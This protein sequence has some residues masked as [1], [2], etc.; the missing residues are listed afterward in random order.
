MNNDLS[1]RLTRANATLA[2]KLSELAHHS[3]QAAMENTQKLISMGNE[4]FGE[5]T[6]HLMNG[7]DWASMA[8]AMSNIPLGVLKMQNAQLQQLT[9]LGIKMNQKNGASCGHV[10]AEWQK[11]IQSAIRETGV[12][13]PIPL[14]M[15]NWGI[16]SS[17]SVA[18]VSRQP[19]QTTG[20]PDEPTV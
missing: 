14:P 9:N 4:I 15:P 10:M 16:P 12:E 6:K 17:A 8:V 2:F 5:N 11:E 3:S 13:L 20:A 18:G 7:T 1:L 19:R